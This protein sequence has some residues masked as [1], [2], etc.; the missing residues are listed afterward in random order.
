MLHGLNELVRI[1]KHRL[2]LVVVRALDIDRMWWPLPDGVPQPELR[3]N[4][5]PLNEGD[6]VARFDFHGHQPPPGFDPHLALQI[7]VHDGPRAPTVRGLSMTNLVS[8][9]YGYVELVVG[10]KFAYF[11]GLP[12][13]HS[14]PLGFS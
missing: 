1:D 14:A 7:R 8:S 4:L 13:R 5:S 11:F 2:L 3:L 9:L 10:L 12:P 6:T